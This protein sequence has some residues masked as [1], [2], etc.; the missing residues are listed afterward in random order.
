MK[1]IDWIKYLFII[2]LLSSC[3]K[4]E[5]LDFYWVIEPQSNIYTN[6]TCKLIVEIP[7][8]TIS[9]ISFFIAG[10]HNLF[11]KQHNK[12]ISYIS[13]GDFYNLYYYNYTYLVINDDTIE[14]NLLNGQKVY[15][16]DSLCLNQNMWEVYN[17]ILL[18]AMK[19]ADKA[20][21]ELENQIIMEMNK[22]ELD[23]PF[24]N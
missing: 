10:K 19:K 17:D 22:P 14:V 13:M 9:D 24:I 8:D 23:D 12:Y 7:N 6:D 5:N 18:D 3:A 1:Q 4:K 20:K 15:L 11:N 2:I 16:F 21:R